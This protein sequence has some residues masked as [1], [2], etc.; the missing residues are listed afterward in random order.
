MLEKN[1]CCFID[2]FQLE[3]KVSKNNFSIPKLLKVFND[4][5]G[6]FSAKAS[7]F[8]RNSEKREAKDHSFPRSIHSVGRDAQ[9]FSTLRWCLCKF[10]PVLSAH[11]S[12]YQPFKLIEKTT[13]ESSSYKL[14]T[15]YIHCKFVSN[16]V[17][18]FLKS[19][20]KWGAFNNKRLA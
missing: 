1:L 16:P 18:L 7:I 6:N 4:K 20:R 11:F 5:F 12:E 2:N 3:N 17:L 14:Q 9:T 8:G 15:F 10:A 19:S 13:S